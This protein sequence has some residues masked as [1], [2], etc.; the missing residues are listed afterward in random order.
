MANNDVQVGNVIIL[1]VYLQKEEFNNMFVLDTAK[2]MIISS[3][4]I[5]KI[6]NPQIPQIDFNNSVKNL[7][8]KV[9][10]DT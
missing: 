4:D 7:K 2:F 3:N 5:N 8:F 6:K 1:C 9:I 10:E